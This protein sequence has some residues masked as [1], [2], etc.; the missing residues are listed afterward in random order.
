MCLLCLQFQA[1]ATHIVGGEITYKYQSQDFQGNN[2]YQITVTIYQDCLTGLPAAIAQ[3]NPAIIS[4]FNLDDSIAPYTYSSY[5]KEENS[6][7]IVPPNFNNS[8]VKNPPQLCLQKTS[9][10]F[11]ETLRKNQKGYRV[12]YQRCCRN[13]SILNIINPSQQ[14]VTYD[15]T[16]P[17]DAYN[18]SAV[19][20]NYP[21]QIICINNPLVYDHSATDMD[22]DSLSYELCQTYGGGNIDSVKPFPNSL[23]YPSILYRSPYSYLI[24]MEGSPLVQID[25]TSGM[26]TGTPNLLGR[27]VVTVCC[28]EWRNHVMINTVRREFQFVVTNCSKAVV[29]DIPQYSDQYNTYIV[30]CKGYTVHFENTSKGGFAYHWDFGVADQPNDTSSEFEPTFTYPDTGVYIVKLVV[31]RGSTCPDSI[32]RFVKIYPTFKA[33]FTDSGLLCPNASIQFNDLSE[34]TYK[35]VNK[36]AWNFGDSTFSNLQDPT[37]SYSVGGNYYVT[38]ISETVK[39]CIDTVKKLIPVDMFKPF[40]GNDTI[41]V[42]GERIYFDASGGYTYT[43]SPGDNLN[44]TNI[45]NP[46]GYYPDTGRYSYRVHIT[47]LN[48]CTG[49]DS[50]H[51]WVI[52]QSEI[53]VPSAFSPNGDGLNDVFRPF[54]VGYKGNNYF[55]VFNRWGQMVFESTDFSRGWDGRFNS[56][57]CDLDTYFWVIDL[58]DRF[59][60]PKRITGDVTLVR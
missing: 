55:R 58:I 50:I 25:P 52:G 47:S 33:D 53:F 51:V 42:K 43:W 40:A 10:V 56:T 22:G 24:P 18:N 13:A 60:K 38:L 59:G 26:I 7:S 29:A 15:C 31:N 9:F 19:F 21:P 28:H 45:Y 2:I 37:H 16:I 36:W 23:S 46:V 12:V 35:P 57:D 11:T 6:V 17:A 5:T 1:R 49:Y 27:F 8:C 39:G 30:E 4:I 14:G 34:A 54:A 20:K 41:I 48:Q 44:D 32:S 3:D